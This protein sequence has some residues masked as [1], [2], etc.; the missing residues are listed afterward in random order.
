[1]SSFKD[2]HVVITGGSKG[3]GRATV[4]IFLRE[5]ARVSIVDVDQQIENLAQHDTQRSYVADVSKEDQVSSTMRS[6]IRHFGAIDVL[7]NNAGIVRYATVS[8]ATEEEWDLIM[9]VNLKSAFLCSK[10]A[11]PSML[12]KGQGVIINISSVQAFASQRKVAAYTTS[13]TALLGLTRSIAVDYAPA[14]RCVAVCPGT[15]DT[16]MLQNA[17]RE[18]ADPEQVYDECIQM[19]PMKK[20]GRPEEVGELIAFLASEKASFITGQAYRVDGGLGIAIEGSKQ[21]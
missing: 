10:H 2:K 7:V 20:I 11:I 5:G 8:E 4:E 16:P 6:A 1:M 12:E 18:S 15:I 21:D 17:I 19:H 3:I 13:K 9:N 14:I